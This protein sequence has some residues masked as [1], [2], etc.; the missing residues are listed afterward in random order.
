MRTSRV[1]FASQKPDLYSTGSSDSRPSVKRR[2]RVILWLT[3]GP[4]CSSTV[5]LL[6]ENGPIRILPNGDLQKNLYAWTNLAHVIWLD[7][8]AGTG[9]SMDFAEL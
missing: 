8:P 1:S 3:G 7:Q 9:W 2:D 6:E 5:A 4:G